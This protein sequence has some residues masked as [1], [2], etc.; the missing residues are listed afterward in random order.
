MWNYD[1]SRGPTEIGT[2]GRRR[3]E[4]GSDGL[5]LVFRPADTG[6]GGGIILELRTSPTP[7]KRPWARLWARLSGTA[8]EGLG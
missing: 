2:A 1:H 5:R 4:Q 8:E 6:Q 3:F 7:K